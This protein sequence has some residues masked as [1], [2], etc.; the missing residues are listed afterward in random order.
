M[1]AQT[2]ERI[3]P[4]GGGVFRYEYT[5]K[6]HLGNGRVSFAANG[7]A[8]QLLQENHYY[9]FGMEM[10][11]AW[12]A[13]SGTENGYQ[14]NGKE[15]NEDWGLNWSNYG[16][17]WYD[18]SVGRWNSIDPLADQMRRW[19]PY[20]YSFDNPIRF[21]DPDG[22]KPTDD[23]FD[24][25]GRFVKHTNTTTNDI[26]VQTKNGYELLHKVPL[27]TTE[28]LR[29]VGNVVRHYG[30]QAGIKTKYSGGEGIVGVKRQPDDSEKKTLAYAQGND[31]FATIQDDGKL[32]PKLSDSK[33][34]TNVLEHEQDHKKKG[35]GFKPSDDYQHAEVYLAQ[36]SSKT[37][38]ETTEGFKAGILGSVAS[39]IENAANGSDGKN[40]YPFDKMVELVNKINSALEGSGYNILFE[41]Y[42]G[43]ADVSVQ[44][45]KKRK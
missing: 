10:K 4:I 9:P 23:Y 3:L 11:G 42:A 21:I 34:L 28:N 25:N 1:S 15:L 27:N 12:I 6:D 19:S 22:R 30:K 43:P 17:R 40:G 37:F 16:A 5:L 20:T 24:K 7:S 39:Y 35:H 44:K 26:Y 8:I 36:I 33:N 31:I 45:D 38:K 41:Q 18:A 13:Q 2:E 14:Y 32:N 29:T